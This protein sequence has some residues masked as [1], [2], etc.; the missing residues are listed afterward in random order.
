MRCWRIDRPITVDGHEHLGWLPIGAIEPAPEPAQSLKLRIEEIEGGA[1]LLV[2]TKKGTFDSWHV[3][4]GEAIDL[5]RA[6]FRVSPDEWT[7][8]EVDEP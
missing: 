8:E 7:V 2:T 3:N 5:A 4:T 1:L 6:N